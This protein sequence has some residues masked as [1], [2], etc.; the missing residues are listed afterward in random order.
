MP[1]AHEIMGQNPDLGTSISSAVSQV[2]NTA[3]GGHYMAPLNH[4]MFYQ[5]QEGQ[6]DHHHGEDDPMELNINPDFGNSESE[7]DDSRSESE[8][9]DK[10]K[11]IEDFRN[12]DTESD[13]EREI[14]YDSD[15]EDT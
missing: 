1:E 7:H 14:S 11:S 2:D 10:G 13:N 6:E 4:E 3:E 9:S 5:S 8:F 15:E 12:S